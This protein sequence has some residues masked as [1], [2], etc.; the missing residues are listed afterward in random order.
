[1]KR[2]KK[3]SISSIP[4]IIELIKIYNSSPVNLNTKQNK[5]YKEFLKLYQISYM[6][7]ACDSIGCKPLLGFVL[8]SQ[9][10]DLYVSSTKDKMRCYNYYTI[11][12]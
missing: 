4:Q 2:M 3:N 10:Y 6:G 8:Y 1:M 9:E 5:E 7:L 11:R 12:D